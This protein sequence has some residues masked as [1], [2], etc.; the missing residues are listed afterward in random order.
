MTTQIRDDL[1][2][3]LWETLLLNSSNG[4]LPHGDIK[5]IADEFG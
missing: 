4:R 2:Q 3:A 5:R 1:A